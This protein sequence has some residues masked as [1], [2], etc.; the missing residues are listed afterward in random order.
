MNR[1]T[2][3]PAGPKTSPALPTT[4][5]KKA[6]LNRFVWD[7]RY[8]GGAATGGGG[9]EG[10]FSGAGPLAPPGAYTARLT[11]NGVT[12]TESFTVRIDPR[13]AKDGITVADL[14]EQ[15]NFA[16]KVRDSL[17]EARR[18]GERV[19]QAMDR[20]GADKAKLEALYYRIVNRPGPY[21]DNMLVEQFANVAREIGQADQ[22]V[23]ASA[24]ERYDE[25][26]RQLSAMKSE[27]DKVV[28]LASP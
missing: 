3:R 1:H 15:T 24:F 12:R 16:L 6:G 7:L 9:E 18:L 21:P 2:S 23:G 4:L 5:P 14:A 11:A 8:P 27:V 10:G 20:P 28:G 13:Y 17:A 25:L 22:K 26:V 19:K